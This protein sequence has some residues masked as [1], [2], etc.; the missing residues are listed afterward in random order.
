MAIGMMLAGEFGGPMYVN[1]MS[2]AVPSLLFDDVSLTAGT[3]SVPR[4]PI[5]PPP[6]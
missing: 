2:L 5:A 1:P 6:T 3:G 4:P